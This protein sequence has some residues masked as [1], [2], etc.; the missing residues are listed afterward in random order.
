MKK[1]I[2][3][4]IFAITLCNSHNALSMEP[5][6]KTHLLIIPGQ[7]G[8][9]G[10]NVETVLP[11]FEKN[12]QQAHTIETP[13][14]LPDFGQNRCQNYLKDKINWLK[15]NEVLRNNPLII[16]ASSQGTATAI[17]YTA[18]NPKNIKCLILESV[19]LSGNSAIEHTINTMMLP[20]VKSIPCDYYGLPYLARCI[21]PSYSPAGEQPID[22]IEALPT[23]LPII[24]L[25]DTQDF[26]LSFKDAQALYAYLTHVKNNKNVYLFARASENG[27]HVLL[28]TDHHTTAITAINTI[29]KIHNLLPSHPNE[30]LSLNAL[31]AYQPK[32]KQKWLDHFYNVRNKEATLK[33]IVNPTV[34]YSTI[35]IALYALYNYLGI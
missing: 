35:L 21:Y 11:Y 25:H 5:E 33:R 12:H 15:E 8:L 3:L 16:H 7:N 34:T 6:N 32:I 22:N 17:N 28:L 1:I 26:Q 31:Q 14:K 27:D 4:C 9:G 20:G 29:L 2:H 23:A 30:R 13:L 10:Q 24:I 18:K 19:M